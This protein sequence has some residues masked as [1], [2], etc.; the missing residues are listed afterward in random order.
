MSTIKIEQKIY[1]QGHSISGINFNNDSS[2]DKGKWLSRPK[3]FEFDNSFV[4]RKKELSEIVEQLKESNILNLYGH[5]GVGKTVFSEYL[6]STCKD[7]YDYIGW[8]DYQGSLI[9]TLN[10]NQLTIITPTELNDKS[11]DFLKLHSYHC[12]TC[13]TNLKGKKLLIIDNISDNKDIE[14]HR[15]LLFL[16]NFKIILTSRERING[17]NSWRFFRLILWSFMVQK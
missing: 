13:L 6:L 2:K 4:R 5:G 1:G 7:E 16:E 11:K 10:C 8:L 12:Q 9:M 3:V 17:F 14:S 15:D